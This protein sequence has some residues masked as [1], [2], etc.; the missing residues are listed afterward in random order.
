MIQL[1]IYSA[2]EVDTFINKRAGEVKLGEELTYCK[3]LDSIPESDAK[4]VVFGISESI[5]VQANYGRLGTEKAWRA[6]LLSF[7]NVQANAY[8]TGKNILLLGAI[9]V[10]P[11]SSI[12]S[13]TPKEELGDIVTRVDRI[14]AQVVET[15]VSAGK[16]PIIIG[17]GHNNAYGNILGTSRALKS[18]INI[19]NIDAHTDL[20]TTDYRHSGNGFSYALQ[21]KK[22][23]LLNKY[24][25]FGLHKNYTPDYIYDFMQRHKEQIYYSHVEDNTDFDRALGYVS[26][27]HFGLELDCDSIKDF[28]SSAQSPSGFTLDQV[29]NYISSTASHSHCTYLHIC[30]AAPTDH[31]SN[32]V[33]KA[34]SYLVTDFIRAYAHNSL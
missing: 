12:T 28:P 16:I 15:I 11:S 5:G 1:N 23:T 8:N 4:F 13:S 17:G 9:K 29:R 26:N 22:P 27:S 20:R 31:D 2:T 34:L 6:F 19:L 25:V 18:P 30:E 21:A 14:V 3:S 33:G 24:A 32:Q 7:L 10:T